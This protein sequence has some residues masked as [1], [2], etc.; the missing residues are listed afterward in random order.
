MSFPESNLQKARRHVAEGTAQV[1]RQA[2]LVRRMRAQ[3][4]DTREPERVLILFDRLL[5]VLRGD[6]RRR[7]DA[8]EA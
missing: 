1:D 6:L 5:T 7:E 3:G 2:A 4:M 8:A